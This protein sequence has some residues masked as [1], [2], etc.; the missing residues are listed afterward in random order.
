V[1]VSCEENVVIDFVIIEMFESP[2]SVGLISLS[3]DQRVVYGV[4]LR[5]ANISY[6]P[7]VSVVR[8]FKSAK[9]GCNVDSRKDDL[10][11]NNAPCSST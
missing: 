3:Y 4:K 11:A 2:I 5:K 1:A 10:I 8:V 7:L 9:P 6:V